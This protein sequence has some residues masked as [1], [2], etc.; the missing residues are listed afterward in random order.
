MKQ[1]GQRKWEEGKQA[2]KEQT[3]NEP[4][5]IENVSATIS[6]GWQEVKEVGQNFYEATTQKI[7]EMTAPETEQKAG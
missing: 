5:I 6:Q 3:T 7:H 2:A 1:E 4:G